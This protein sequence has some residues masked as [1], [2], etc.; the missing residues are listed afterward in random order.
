MQQQH[1]LCLNDLIK[2]LKPQ[3]SNER[4]TVSASFAEVSLN[5]IWLYINY[6][7]Q[8]IYLYTIEAS[9]TKRL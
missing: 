4:L 2:M 1:P 3:T 7:F 5:T 6:N 9:L 8:Y